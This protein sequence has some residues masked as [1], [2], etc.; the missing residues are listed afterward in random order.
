M[1]LGVI[2]TG[3]IASAVVRGIAGDG[4]QITVSERSASHAAAL[5]AEFDNVSV[6]DNQTVLDQSD[7]VFVALMTGVARAVLGSLE[8]RADQRVITFMGGATLA[9]ADDM[10][11]PATAVAIMMPFPGIAQGGSPIM[12]HGDAALV[13]EIFG[14]HNSVFDLPNAEEMA[15]YL[16]AQAVLS[17]VVRMVDDAANWLGERVSDPAQGEEFLRV[18][19]ASNLMNTACAPLI[20]ALNTPG[21]YNQRLRLHMEQSGMGEALEQG[22]NK[23]ERGE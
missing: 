12:M 19:V 1:R 9:Q 5:A 23:L 3:T 17:P 11:S 6:A 21:G 14:A 18:L 15:A 2:G 16:S 4:H 20:D 13:G 8:F 7:V 22:L 10:V